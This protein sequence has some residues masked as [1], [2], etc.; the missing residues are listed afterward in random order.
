MPI[1]CKLDVK[2]VDKS[3]MFNSTRGAVYLDV[4]LIENRDGEDKYGNL[5]FVVQSLPKE[6]R[7]AGEKGPI[8]G[9]WKRV[10]K[11]AGPKP[12]PSAAAGSA[13]PPD[14]DIPF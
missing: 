7:E 10:G 11:D 9:N 13:P 14:D 3:A 4:A 2:K 8:I 5:G 6:R 1:V 12:L